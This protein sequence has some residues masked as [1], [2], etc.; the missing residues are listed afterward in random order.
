VRRAGDFDCLFPAIKIAGVFFAEA[1]KRRRADRDTA[2]EDL[3]QRREG[4]K[5]QGIQNFIFLCALGVFASLR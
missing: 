1:R 3:T 5:A 4:A 2:L